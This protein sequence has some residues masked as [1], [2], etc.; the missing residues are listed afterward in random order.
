MNQTNLLLENL[1]TQ[2]DLLKD[3]RRRQDRLPVNDIPAEIM[4]IDR[5]GHLFI[6]RTFVE[7]VSDLGCRFNSRTVLHCGDIVSVKPLMPGEKVMAEQQSQL[8]EV[9]WTANHGTSCTVG[10]RKLQGE[11]LENA[12]FPPPNY[13]P[14]RPT[15]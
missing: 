12:K 9:M 3:G 8:F 1:D 7:D 13:S 6:E 2:P 14:K 10:A 4:G 5:A 15:K 11:K